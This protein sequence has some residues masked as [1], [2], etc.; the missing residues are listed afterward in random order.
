ME[1]TIIVGDRLWIDKFTY[2]AQLPKRFADIPLLNVFTWIKPLRLADRKNDWGNKRM[3]GLRMPRIG[4]LVVFESPEPPYPLLVKRIASRL[5]TGDTIVIHASNYNDLHHIAAC[6]GKD[7]FMKNDSVFINGKPES[8]CI[9]SQPY[10]RMLGDNRKNS[11]DSRQ[12]G[13][14]PCSSVVG[15]MN[16]VFFSINTDNRFVARIRWNRFFKAIK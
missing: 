14:I 6:E 10:Y 16:F 8:I 7:I 11:Y 5:R 2:G 12:F 3:K 1:P 9:L 13:Y 4:D 15:R